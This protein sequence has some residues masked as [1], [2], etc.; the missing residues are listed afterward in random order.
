MEE[1]KKQE[2]ENSYL[3]SLL[4]KKE[5]DLA[6]DWVCLDLISI[7]NKLFNFNVNDNFS[8]IVNDVTKTINLI[9]HSVRI[10]HKISEK[11]QQK[12]FIKNRPMYF[13][14]ECMKLVD[15]MNQEEKA[16]LVA[17]IFKDVITKTQNDNKRNDKIYADTKMTENTYNM[18]QIAKK[19][20]QEISSII[21]IHVVD[22]GSIEIKF[23]FIINNKNDFIDKTKQI[24][25]ISQEYGYWCH[26]WDGVNLLTTYKIYFRKITEEE[27]KLK[28]NES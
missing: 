6:L 13:V 2:E 16:E 7:K 19:L 14:K 22:E 21:D 8:D 11:I 26:K 20:K 3:D 23:P 12:Y 10:K 24:E 1:L 15:N 25:K 28:N 9:N 18:L 4:E 5:Y 17:K 27:L